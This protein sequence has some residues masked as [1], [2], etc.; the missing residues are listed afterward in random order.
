MTQESKD[1]TSDKHCS[2][3]N[4]PFLFGIATSSASANCIIKPANDGRLW[5]NIRYKAVRMKSGTAMA[6]NSG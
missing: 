6:G 1:S 5:K 3:T 4:P 2:I